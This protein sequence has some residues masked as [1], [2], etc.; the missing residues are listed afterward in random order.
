MK[1]T[2]NVLPIVSYGICA[3][4]RRW[5]EARP[6]VWL[7][8]AALPLLGAAP[9]GDVVALT[10]QP[11]TALKAVAQTLAAQDLADA[12]KAGETP[13]LLVGSARL[14]PGQTQ[15]AL[16]IQVQSAALCGSAGCSTS[17]FLK[18]GRGWKKILDSVS[19]PIAVSPVLHRGMHDLLI[20]SRDRWVW[21]GVVYKDTLP[22]PA[23]LRPTPARR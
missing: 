6:K 1:N 9:P 20:D 4:R 10:Q 18:R 21:D 3:A 15:A 5:A 11:G 17:V 12:K 16:F 2:L 19:G 8:V 14:A 23:A 7:T 22:G 13:A